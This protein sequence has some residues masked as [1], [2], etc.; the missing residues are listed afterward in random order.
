MTRRGWYRL[1]LCVLLLTTTGMARGQKSYRAVTK[2]WTRQDTFYGHKDFFAQ[3]EWTVTY[4]SEPYLTARL[5]EYSERFDLDDR[6]QESYW[7]SD[8]EPYRAEPSFFIV[9][10]TQEKGWNRLDELDNPLWRLALE[11]DG[12]SCPPRAVK[13]L[14]KPSAADRFFFPHAELWDVTYLASFP[15]TCRP[16]ETKPFALTIRGLYGH[17]SLNWK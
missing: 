12:R 3:L 9:F 2:E 11:Q 6:A 7:Q 17:S 14:G 13:R 5:A 4:L 8:L 1:G 16:D 15:S 10:Y